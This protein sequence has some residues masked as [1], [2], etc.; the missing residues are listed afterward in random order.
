MNLPSILP[1]CKY[2]NFFIA[3]FSCVNDFMEEDV[4]FTVLVKIC[5]VKSLYNRVTGSWIWQNFSVK[6]FAAIHC[7]S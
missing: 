4:G 2:C 3:N 7:Y 1:M 6:I 5:S